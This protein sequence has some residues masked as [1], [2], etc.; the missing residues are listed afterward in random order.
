MNFVIPFPHVLPLYAGSENMMLSPEGIVVVS[1]I[2]QKH[3]KLAF[4]LIVKDEVENANL[5]IVREVVL[6]LTVK[7]ET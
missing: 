3:W 6:A 4:V 7:S 5:S 1:S 2:V